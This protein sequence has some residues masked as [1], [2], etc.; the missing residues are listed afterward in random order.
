MRYPT[1]FPLAVMPAGLSW[2]FCEAVSLL[3][4]GRPQ[5]FLLLL[6]LPM[7]YPKTRS[8]QPQWH[9]LGMGCT[10]YWSHLQLRSLARLLQMVH[11]AGPR[12]SA[13]QLSRTMAWWIV[14]HRV[15]IMWVASELVP[16][17]VAAQ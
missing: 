13:A 4:A 16:F 5:G 12:A 6:L 14:S 1:K 15:A 10:C 2:V 3:E 17:R 9:L 7:R 8:H 11:L